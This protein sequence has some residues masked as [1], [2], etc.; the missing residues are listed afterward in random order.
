MYWLGHYARVVDQLAVKN[1]AQ[2]A[3]LGGVSTLH[4]TNSN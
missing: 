4:H 2:G 1:I 3:P